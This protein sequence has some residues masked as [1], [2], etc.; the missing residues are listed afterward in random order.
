ME[1]KGSDGFLV[2]YYLSKSK[3]KTS[4]NNLIDANR[5]TDFV[6]IKFQS[7][8]ETLTISFD[9]TKQSLDWKLK[10]K[11]EIGGRENG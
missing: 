7:G 5:A 1:R 8:T 10:V 11:R 9:I 4:E 2:W 6:A 3:G